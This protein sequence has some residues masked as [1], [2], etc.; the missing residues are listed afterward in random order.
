M[1]VTIMQQNKKQVIR[2]TFVVFVY[3]CCFFFI[4][5]FNVKLDE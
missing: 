2:D 5:D 4:G 3:T 1:P